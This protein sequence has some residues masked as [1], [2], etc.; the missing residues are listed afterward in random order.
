[1]AYPCRILYVD[2]DKDSCEL[3]KAMLHFDGSDYEVIAVNSSMEAL[4][5]LKSQTFDLYI[6]DYSLPEISGV[7]LCRFIRN[8]DLITPI[9]FLSAR[10]FSFERAEGFKAGANEYLIKPNDLNKLTDTIN[11]LINE[12][13]RAD[14][15]TLNKPRVHSGIY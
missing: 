6:L 11:R 9:M 8:N 3:L 10:A 5:I 15:E 7:E 14:C 1:M 13:P 4:S 2:D 12:N